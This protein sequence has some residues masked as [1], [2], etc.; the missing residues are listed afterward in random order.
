MLLSARSQ[1]HFANI[2]RSTLRRI[3]EELLDA[4]GDKAFR[5]TIQL[6]ARELDVRL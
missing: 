6:L 3:V 2:D 1:R 4:R 5:E